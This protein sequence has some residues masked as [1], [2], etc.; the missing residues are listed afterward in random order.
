M[1]N[2]S[3]II[4]GL[5]VL[6]LTAI[7]VSE[8]FRPRP[9]DWRPN[10]TSTGKMP[11]GC[12]ILYNELETLF[13]KGVEIVEQNLFETF[14]GGKIANDHHYLIINSWVDFDQQETNQLLNF[15]SKGNSVFIASTGL[16][17]ALQD[18]LNIA[19]GADYYF[20]E[21]TITLHLTHNKFEQ[22]AYHYDKA[23]YK[24]HFVSVDSSN[25]T[26]LGT[27]SYHERNE[28]TQQKEQIV[29]HPNF[30]K[31]RYGK[32][33]FYLH[34]T[35]QAF[36]NYYL[37]KGNAAYALHTMSYLPDQPVY[38][39]NFK[40]SGRVVIESPLRFILTQ[41]PLRWAYYVSMVSLILFLVFKSK[42]E[43]RIIP[44]W[45]KNENSTISF[46]KT[47]GSL[48]YQ[49]KNYTDIITKKINYF[50][51]YLRNRY[52]LDTQELG[53][54]MAKQLAYKSGKNLKE[55]KRL[56]DLLSNLKHK[57]HHSSEDLIH[58]NKKISSFK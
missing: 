16:G 14:L 57:N 30:I 4:L 47:V 27:V 32:G 58:L 20:K 46:T 49:N 23:V 35:P 9:L 10:Y 43:Q 45:P 3:K 38:W 50:L 42:R 40:K 24:N 51:T 7:T 26:I 5:L 1:D 54:K 6:V 37:K 17:Y 31:T 18:T 48:Y 11:L 21:D 13:P 22:Q 15:V 52:Y 41:D 8:V 12:Y 33:N 36:T 44:Q 28:I 55:T 53:D 39:D 2:R 19:F 56:I 34:S 29:T 25:T